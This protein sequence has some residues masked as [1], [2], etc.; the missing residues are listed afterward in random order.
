LEPLRQ[1]HARLQKLAGLAAG[2]EFYLL[3]EPHT[4][5]LKLMYAGVVLEEYPVLSISLGQ[6][7]VLFVDRD[8]PEDA[9]SEVWEQGRLDPERKVQRKEIIP[10]A[11]GAAPSEEEV[12]IPPTPE[13][14][15][16]APDS[17]HV[18]YR[19]GKALEIH[20]GDGHSRDGFW[21]RTLAALRQ[22]IE[23]ATAAIIPSDTD[24]VRLRV[25]LEGER[26]RTLYRALPDN[27]SF[28]LVQ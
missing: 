19:S 21:A 16:P 8:L 3:L 7:E 24:T 25:V 4:K 27:S 26:A 14:A 12:V 5:R 17:Y 18:R 13:E 2:K 6:R 28:F 9:L 11:D 20:A 10:P 15:V 23:D 22:R 1:E